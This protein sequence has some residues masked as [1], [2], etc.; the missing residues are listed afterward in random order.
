MPTAI[1]D[2][3]APVLAAQ[4]R[5]NAMPDVALTNEGNKPAITKRKANK[6]F[7]GKAT[8]KLRDKIP[9]DAMALERFNAD[10]SEAEFQRLLSMRKSD[11]AGMSEQ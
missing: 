8:Q 4:G 6:L 3:L 9:A 5:T 11:K 2:K 7:L 1:A 10:G